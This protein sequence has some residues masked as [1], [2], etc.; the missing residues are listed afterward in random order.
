[1]DGRNTFVSDPGPEVAYAAGA[2]S[3]GR[4][5]AGY[6]AKVKTWYAD[7]CNSTVVSFLLEFNLLASM[8]AV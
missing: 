1:M 5:Q 2:E 6:D 3:S 8:E 4:A 7:D